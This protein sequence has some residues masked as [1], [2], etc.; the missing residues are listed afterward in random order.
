LTTF[1]AAE[2]AAAYLRARGVSNS[3]LAVILGSGL[4]VFAERVQNPTVIPYAEIP[5]WPVPTVVGHGGRL[6]AGDVGGVSVICLQGR[7]HY[8]EGH[9]MERVIFPTRVLGQLGVKT[10]IVTN[11]AGGMN[12]GFAPGDLMIVTDHLN[13][14]GVNPLRG[15]HDERFGPR[16]TDLT[17]AYDRPMQEQI[18]QTS[19]QLGTSA[20][21]GVYAAVAGPSYETPAE[22]RMLRTIG[23]DAVGMST[24]PEVLA[25]RQMGMRVGAISV[26]TNAAAGVTGE[27]LSHEEVTETSRRVGARFSDLLESAIPKL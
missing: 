6:L 13:L 16:F 20:V 25:A 1:D 8:Y 4:G 18:I 15:V 23:A 10:L 24:V 7:A 21:R 11:A 3:P 27:P 5:H 26:I 12:P 9:P 2:E 17:H 14:M 19:F 22:I